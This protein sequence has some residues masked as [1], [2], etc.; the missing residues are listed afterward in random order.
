MRVGFLLAL[1]KRK[2]LHFNDDFY[3]L[4]SKPL[5][6]TWL[7]FNEWFGDSKGFIEFIG[8]IALLVTIYYSEMI[9]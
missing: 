3:H 2:I 4:L 6:S 1:E 8:L 5:F 9:V 7:F